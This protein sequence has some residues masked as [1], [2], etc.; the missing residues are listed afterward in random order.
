MNQFACEHP[1][2]VRN[3]Y[4]NDWLYVPCGK[5]SL[6]RSKKAAHWTERLEQERSCHP[7]C[8]FGT[9]TYN[10]KHLP[11]VLLADDGLLDTRSGELIPFNEISD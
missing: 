11:K 9:L 4:T 8:L 6:C 10:E 3:P 2:K 7:Y 5:C 1:K